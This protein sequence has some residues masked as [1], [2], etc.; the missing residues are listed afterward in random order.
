MTLDELETILRE[1]GG[2]VTISGTV[3]ARFVAKLFDRDP[4]TLRRWKREG[5]GPPRDGV[6]YS[7]AALA[8]WI[9]EQ[10]MSADVLRNVRSRE[11]HTLPVAAAREHDRRRPRSPCSL[12]RRSAA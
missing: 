12:R 6:W 5:K 8:A 4:R 7:L 10:E 2:H 11:Q 3:H 9:D 1:D